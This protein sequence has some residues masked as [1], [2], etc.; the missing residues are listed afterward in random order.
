[1]RGLR[2]WRWYGTQE[3]SMTDDINEVVGALATGKPGIVTV[4]EWT[5]GADGEQYRFFWAPSWRVITD[6]QMP[7]A[8]FRSTE[9]W[10]LLACDGDVV[11]AL[12]PGCQVRGMV[13]CKDPPPKRDVC[14]LG[15]GE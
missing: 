9:R 2:L 6:K 8:G 1:M 4:S 12:I 15:G 13:F 14:V 7:I 3:G 10:Q 11:L 5:A